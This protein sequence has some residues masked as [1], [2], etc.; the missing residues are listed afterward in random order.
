MKLSKFLPLYFVV[1][2]TLLSCSHSKSRL[3]LPDNVVPLQVF[4]F[5]SLICEYVATTDTLLQKE[6]IDEAGDFWNVYNFHLLR[7]HDS[8]AFLHGLSAFVNDTIISR[9]I[10]DAQCQYADMTQLEHELSYLSA[11]YTLLFPDEPYPI[12][13][14]H[15]S[16]LGLSV[17][18]LDSVVSFSLDCYLGAD[19]PIYPYRYHNYELA[20]HQPS[21]IQYDVAEVLLRN[22]YKAHERTT[23]LDAMIYEGIVAYGMSCMTDTDSIA[24]ILAF[25]PQQILWCENNEELIWKNI[26]ENGHLFSSDNMLINKYIQ[27]SPFASPLTQDAPGRVGRWIG[28]RIV[29]EY[30]DKCKVSPYDLLHDSIAY[31]EILRLSGYDAK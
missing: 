1:I 10:S 9:L 24:T 4:R 27:P 5:D 3:P 16:G 7:L 23:L 19:Y 8:P 11:R 18:T 26:V 6:I 13:Q 29:S 15:I 14:S 21:R 17:V 12:Y 22:A 30:A 20:M 31:S 28:F 25:S 2:L